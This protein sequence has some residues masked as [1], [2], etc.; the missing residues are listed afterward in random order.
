MHRTLMYTVNQKK[1]RHHT[2]VD[3]FTKAW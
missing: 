1:T 2:H 3:N